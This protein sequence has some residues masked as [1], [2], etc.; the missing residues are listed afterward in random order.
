MGEEHGE[1]IGAKPADPVAIAHGRHQVIGETAQHLIAGCMAEAVVDQLE[2]IQV[3]VAQRMR[4]A[5]AAHLQQRAFQQAFDLAAVDQ[6]GQRLVAGVVL[7][8]TRQRMVLADVLDDREHRQPPAAVHAGTTPAPPDQA[9]VAPPEAQFA[10]P[11]LP[12]PV[13]AADTVD[14][15][16]AVHQQLVQ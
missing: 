11:Q 13:N 14:D 2:M 8:L 1:L 12:V 6:A 10:W 5:V 15:Q 3:Y 9:A 16:L 7:D 4:A